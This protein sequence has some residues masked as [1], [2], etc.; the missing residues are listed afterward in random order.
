MSSAMETRAQPSAPEATSPGKAGWRGLYRLG[1]VLF[2]VAGL[3]SVVASRLGSALYPSGI[4]DNA[5][6]YLQLI[7]QHQ[8]LAN[9][10]WSLWIFLD[11][12]LIAPSVAVYFA[13]RRDGRVLA[14]LGTLLSLFFVFYDISVTE[15]NSLTLVSLSHGYASAATIALKAP[16]I[17]AATYGYT[18]LPLQTVLSFGIGSLGYLLWSIV[19]LRGSVFHRWV[20]VLGIL[21]GVLGILG[22]AAPVITGSAVL[23]ICQYLSIPLMGLW[24]VFLGV[25]LFR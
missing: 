4:P 12:L 24:F 10:L 13:L 21:V 1:G 6:A 15:L 22:A 23:G 2:V 14:L 17:S 16:Y 19:M 11:F 5:T 3:A 25:I 8:A 20:A 9:S 7:S 18:A